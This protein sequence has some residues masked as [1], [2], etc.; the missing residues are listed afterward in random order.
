[1]DAIEASTAISG[2]VDSGRLKIFLDG[3]TATET[4]E[5]R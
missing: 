1:M 2:G 4:P 5:Q 3:L